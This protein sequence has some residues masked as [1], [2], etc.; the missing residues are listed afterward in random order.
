MKLCIATC[1]FPVSDNIRRNL[2]YV[3]LQMH[4]AKQRGAHVAHFPE[5]CLSGY[6]GVDLDSHETMDWDQLIGTTHKITKL[7]ADL[8]LWVILGSSHRLTG[9]HKPHNSL[10]IINSQGRIVDR[11]DKRFCTGDRLC[12]GGD[13]A[14]YTPGRHFAV[15]E[16]RG[17]RCGVLICYDFRFDEL[18]RRYK[19]QG[20]QL[21]LHSYYN[22]GASA[23]ALRRDNILGV[24]VA[25]TMQAYAAN[26]YMWI[27]ASNSS[28]PASCWASFFVRPDGRIVG[29]LIKNRSGVLIN[30]VD[31]DM[32]FYDASKNWRDRALKGVLHSGRLVQDRRS[33]CRDRL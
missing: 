33:Q 5:T 16:I 24:I 2:G 6:A 28:R 32:S 13:L 10:Y 22:A 1:Q 25:P 18:Y 14:H 19:Q 31:P 4:R 26:N 9:R 8:R 11:Y 17:V 12:R 3:L 23:V 27:S 20:V 21:M 29:R 30:T 15:F 7:A